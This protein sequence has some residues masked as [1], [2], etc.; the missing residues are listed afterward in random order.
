MGEPYNNIPLPHRVLQT[1]KSWATQK[2]K[3]GKC[4]TDSQS[5][6]KMK[7]HV[8]NLCK[9]IATNAIQAANSEL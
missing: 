2:E 6:N 7:L 9:F 4:S 1:E 5:D 8:E 3:Q